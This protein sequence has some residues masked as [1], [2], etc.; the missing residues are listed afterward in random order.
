MDNSLSISGGNVIK[1]FGK[2][3]NNLGVNIAELS[4]T[5]ILKVKTG[6]TRKR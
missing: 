3:E 6:K 2:L 4:L 1:I 5:E